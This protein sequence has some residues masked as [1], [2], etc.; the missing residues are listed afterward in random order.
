[1]A[2]EDLL[3]P[4]SHSSG[5]ASYGTAIQFRSRPAEAARQAKQEGKLLLLLHVS[6]N[7]EDAKFT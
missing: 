2:I 6:G 1:V 3:E 4:L 5:C 7:F